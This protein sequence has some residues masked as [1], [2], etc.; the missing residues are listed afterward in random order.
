MENL[1]RLPLEIRRDIIN[2]TINVPDK[3]HLE[4]IKQELIWLKLE[5]PNNNVH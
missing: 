1:E 4:V 3:P 2:Q 5:L